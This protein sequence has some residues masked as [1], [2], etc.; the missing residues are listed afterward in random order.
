MKKV[1]INQIKEHERVESSFLVTKKDLARSKAGKPYLNLTL[2]DNTGEMEAR[3]WEEAEEISGRFSKDDIVLVKGHAVS[4]RDK[5]QLNVSSVRS[6]SGDEYSLS[7]YLPASAFDPALMMAE[8]ETFV[9]D[10]PDKHIK[11]LLKSILTDPELRVRFM[12]AP[13]AKS[14]HHPYLGGLLEHVL[15]LVRL[16]KPV[17]NNYDGINLSLVTAGLILHDIGKVYELSY[18]RSF[19]YTD[20]G[21]LLGHIVQ[22]LELVQC[23][24]KRLPDFPEPLALLLKH[25]LISH[26][27][28][29]EF[30]SP[31][32][33]KTL[34]ALIVS[35]L[36]DMDAKLNAVSRATEE[37]TV[38]GGEAPKWTR[39]HRLLERYLYKGPNFATVE[40]G[41]GGEGGDEEEGEGAPGRRATP[42]KDSKKPREPKGPKEHRMPSSEGPEKKPSTEPDLFREKD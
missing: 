15:S 42:D 19:E 11:A 28:I 20:E 5:V 2:S 17:V 4:Y 13:A 14:M 3:V 10:V 31:K 38:E 26:H 36:D 30:G 23:H 7:D 34:E 32:R 16:A 33:P 35:H 29:L 9:E 27:G 18:E 6:L 22:G 12:K 40:G 1:W 37:E 39:Y 21:R 41:E 8:L 25:I 24:I